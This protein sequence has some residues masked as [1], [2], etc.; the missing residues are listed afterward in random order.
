M[1]IIIIT[2]LL[3]KDDGIFINR[4]KRLRYYVTLLQ[5]FEA[6]MTYLRYCLNF[7]YKELAESYENS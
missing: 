3:L 5:V 6:V 7:F 2:V 1:K 4:S